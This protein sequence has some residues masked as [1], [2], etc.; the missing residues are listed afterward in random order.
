[1]NALLISAIS[2]PAEALLN[3]VIAQDPAAAAKLLP[4]EGKTIGLACTAPLPWEVFIQVLD[5]RLCIRTVYEPQP[6][7]SISANASAFTRLLLSSQ[8]TDALFSPQISLSGDTHLI[9]TLHAS[10]SAMEIDWEEHVGNVFGDIPTFQLG[11]WLHS[12]RRWTRD[13]SA[14]LLDDVEEYLHEE[15]KLLP[16][17]AEVEHFNQRLD[18]LKLAI[19]RIKA[20]A[21]RL[22]RTLEQDVTDPQ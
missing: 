12:S 20:R 21:E 16:S 5:N 2:A 15:A 7:A 11:Q 14:A 3:T 4:L 22:R 10:I 9:Q 19:D 6:D 17:A 13:V 8:Q 1:M 18:E